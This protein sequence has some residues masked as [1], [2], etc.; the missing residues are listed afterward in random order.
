MSV[1]APWFLFFVFVSFAIGGA[2]G[3]AGATDQIAELQAE[4]VSP[5]LIVLNRVPSAR[6]MTIKKITPRSDGVFDLD[7]TYGILVDGQGPLK[8]EL[9]LQGAERKI[10]FTTQ[11]LS[12]VS[13]T[14]ISSGSFQG[15]LTDSKGT[16]TALTM[17]RMSDA[18]LRLK[19]AAELLAK[20]SPEVPES[21]SRFFGGWAGTWNRS[22]G[23]QRLW[24]LAM[25]ADCSAKVSYLRSSSNELP[26]GFRNVTIKEG[27]MSMPCGNSGACSFELRGDEIW[28]KYVDGAGYNNSGVFR[29]IQ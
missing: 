9:T 6:G 15:T 2:R 27:V 11:A 3:Q 29:K 22:A 18:E 25:K 28:A 8:A 7:I 14:Q 26:T 13:A 19:A 23:E 24:V 10:L 12:K 16:V 17:T 1:R 5:W 21:C 4:L 20:P